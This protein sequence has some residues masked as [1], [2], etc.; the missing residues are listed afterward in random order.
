[1]SYIQDNL[2]P[3]EKILFLAKVHPAVF[4]PAVVLFATS[5]IMGGYVFYYGS[6]GN[7]ID[8]LLSGLFLLLA[9]GLFF[10]SIYF[11]AEALITILE[12]EFAITNRRVI[13]K[14]GFIRRNT[15]EMLLPKIESVAVDQ[16]VLGRLLNFGTVT[17]T[18]TGGTQE[19]FR[20]IVT[21]LS[22]RKKINQIIEHFSQSQKTS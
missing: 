6:Q 16:S 20:A 7:N 10:S 2:M 22:M 21:P 15:L 9:I 3:K 17:I 8:S 5:L 19:S 11:V 18:G 13:A 1:M 4:L 14:T 12:T